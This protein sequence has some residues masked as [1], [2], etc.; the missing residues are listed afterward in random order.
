MTALPTEEAAAS[1]GASM[2]M[3]TRGRRQARGFGV[4]S[5]SPWIFSPSKRAARK[6]RRQRH[7]RCV[8]PPRP[9]KS[10]RCA[11]HVP[12][13]PRELRPSS[14]QPVKVRARSVCRRASLEPS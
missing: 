9:H 7:R 13:S 11:S 12:S 10:Q 1:F 3:L 14:P 8:Y 4:F 5:F 6:S 2:Q